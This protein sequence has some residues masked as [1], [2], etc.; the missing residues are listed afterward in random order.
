MFAPPCLTC[1]LLS[2]VLL[3]IPH[4]V[5]SDIVCQVPPTI[6][7]T[8]GTCI[9]LSTNQSDV[10]SWGVKVG[11]QNANEICAVPSTVVNS[12]FLASSELCNDDQLGM[13]GLQWSKQQCRSR[14]GG[15]IDKHKVPS[16]SIEGLAELNPEWGALDNNITE[17]VNATLQLGRHS[18]ATIAALFSDG[19]VST[20]SHLGLAAGSTLL[21]DLKEN[22]LIGSKSWGLDAGS[23]SLQS[24][25]AGSLVLGGFDEASVAGPF[26]EYDVK[27]PDKLENR[28]CP[29]QVLVTGLALTAKGSNTTKPVSR[30]FVSNANKWMAC[31]EP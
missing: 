29:L 5:T 24:P 1:W 17:A 2:L 16:A 9:I 26:F 12:T 27:S 3:G 4:Q 20:S 31:I 18:I 22:G 21:H 30:T 10:H 19:N 15:F 28:Y 25:R 6:Q 14:R 11:V 7:L 8:L 13:H 23:K